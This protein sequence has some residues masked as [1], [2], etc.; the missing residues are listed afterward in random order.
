MPDAEGAVRLTIH[1]DGAV[2]WHH[3]PAYAEFVHRAHREGLAGASVFHGL[4]GFGADRRIYHERPAHLAAKGPCTVVLVDQEDRLRCF[5]LG[6]RD[7]L[8]HTEALAV[9]DR[10]RIHRAGARAAG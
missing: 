8:E 4:T 10:V 2:L 3:R 1:L 7:V 6:V 9:L 5:L